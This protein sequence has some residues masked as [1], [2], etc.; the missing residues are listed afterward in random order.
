MVFDQPTVPACVCVYNTYVCVWVCV[1]V[2]LHP[3]DSGCVMGPAVA[4]AHF[5]YGTSPTSPY[6]VVNGGGCKLSPFTLAWPP[7]ANGG[8]SSPQARFVC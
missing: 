6:A 3:S 4:G 1:C 8:F 2:S 7:W 5:F